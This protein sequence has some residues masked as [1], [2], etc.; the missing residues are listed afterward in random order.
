[1]Q[2]SLNLCNVLAM[3][4]GGGAPP[5]LPYSPPYLLQWSLAQGLCKRC[6]TVWGSAGGGKQSYQALIFLP[7]RKWKKLD[8]G[9][10]QRQEALLT[11]GIL[12]LCK[13]VAPSCHCFITERQP[14]I[15]TFCL[16]REQGSPHLLHVFWPQTHTVLRSGCRCGSAWGVRALWEPVLEGWRCCGCSWG[17][18]G[19]CRGPS[20]AWLGHS[21]LLLLWKLL[22]ASLTQY[23]WPAFVLGY[24]GWVYLLN[25]GEFKQLC[26]T[27]SRQIFYCKADCF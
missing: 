14:E 19:G 16:K 11:A 22:V 5:P 12:T 20:H 2:T 25:A 6:S 1:M 21:H 9:T 27:Q 26:R 7:Q 15:R 17:L 10:G 18:Q 24:C 23:I 13:A 8:I 3:K 4:V